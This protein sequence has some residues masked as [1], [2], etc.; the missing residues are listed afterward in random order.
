MRRYLPILIAVA[1]LVS[2]SPVL[3]RDFMQA[4]STNVPLTKMKE[5]PLFYTGKLYILGGLIVKTRNFDRGSIIEAIYIP[6]DSLGYLK[7][8]KHAKDRFLAF[9]PVSAGFL[10]PEIYQKGRSVTVAGEFIELR[11]GKIDD[12]DYT[13]PMFEIKQIHLWEEQKEYYFP[14]YYYPYPPYPYW[15]HDPLWRH[16][17]YPPYWWY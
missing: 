6:V 3:R 15:W 9:L 4:G 7:D 16:R 17:A 12:A 2:C 10:D 11:H 1:L 13:F 14:P 5:T 8:R